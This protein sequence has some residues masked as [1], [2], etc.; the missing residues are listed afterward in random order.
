[1]RS[2][3]RFSLRLLPELLALA[4]IFGGASGA[5][6]QTPAESAVTRAQQT[7]DTSDTSI[8]ADPRALYQA[9]NELKVDGSRV[10][11][12]HDL[13]VRRDAVHLAF[14][15]GTLAFLQ[16]L[17]GRVTGAVFVGRG[18]VVATP[19]DAGERRSLSHFLG[20]PILDQTFSNAYLRFTDDTAAELQ[21]EIESSGAEVTNDPGF[22]ARWAPGLGGLAPSHSLRVMED[23]Y[24]AD[25]LPYFYALLQNDAMGRFDVV[26]DQRRDEQVMLGQLR[27]ENGVEAYDVWASFRAEDSPA[28]PLENFLPVKYAVDSTIADDLTLSGKTVLDLKA[29]RSG[30]RMVQ[31]ELSRNL[32]VSEIRGDDGKPV[33]FFQNE[34]LS[35]QEATRRGNDSIVV[36]LP[37]AK[38]A[39]EEIHLEVAYRGNVIASAGNGV[40]FVG[41]RGT[42]F[43]HVGGEHFATFDLSFRWP[44]R[45]TLVATGAKVES[46]DDT[47]PKSGRWRSEIPFA[48]A[49]FNLGEYKVATTGE[50]PKVYIYANK[51]LEDAI[52]SRLQERSTGRVDTSTSFIHPLNSTVSSVVP[53]PPPP[54]PTAALNELGKQ[55]LDSIRYFSQTNGTFPFE[56]LDIAQ[57]PGSFG[58]GWPGLVYLSTLAFLPADT[59]GQAGITEWAQRASRNLMPFHEVVHQWWGNETVAASYRDTWIEEG[60]ANYL[61]ILYS[62][63]KK[64][65]EH[66]LAGWLE[67]YRSDLLSK[68]AGSNE[69]IEHMGPLTLGTRLASPIVPDAYATIMYGKGTW[70]FHMLHELMREPGSPDPDA[71]FRQLLQSILKEYK[72]QPFS[73]A[74]FQRAIE[75]RMNAAM[76]VEGTHRMTW[77]FDEWVR[78]TGVPHYSV[79]YEVKT[80]G[81]EFV[82]SGVLE[83]KGVVDSF[84]A[85]VPIY[86]TRVGGKP[87]KLGVVVTTGPQTRF[88]F[89]ARV[90]PARIAIDPQLTVLCTTN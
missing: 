56:R 60:L 49:G 14:T 22:V 76:D 78:G 41:E 53:A 10:Y 37:A 4:T 58:Q 47:D 19:R 67:H 35:P 29:A 63:S 38:N 26:V 27:R 12:V 82:V 50:S 13:T 3:L 16:P 34:D 87:E 7:S 24:S 43:A 46:H 1:M 65:G 89:A 68:T 8:P 21:R 39:G 77:F 9:L 85:P 32:A 48:T 30:E 71:K 75:Q 20:V 45:L 81:Q 73:T 88:H 25:P 61:A 80:K 15:E 54:S 90:R 66:R 33:I 40:E 51:E 55:V 86:G 74:D 42:W 72:F 5:G 17:G 64:P 28:K 59:Q 84:T 6:A 69:T 83:Q 79:K 18:H 52:T 23:F 36:V 57:I 62:D 70:V 44:K 2:L 11:A 31:L